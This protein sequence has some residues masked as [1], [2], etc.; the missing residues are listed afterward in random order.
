[1]VTSHLLSS[2]AAVS[3]NELPYL[4]LASADF[5]AGELFSCFVTD[6][7][8]GLG[9]P[10]RNDCS[11]FCVG[12]LLDAFVALDLFPWLEQCWLAKAAL[13]PAKFREIFG[14]RGCGSALG[15]VLLSLNRAGWQISDPDVSKNKRERSSRTEELGIRFDVNVKCDDQILLGL[16]R[17][18]L[19]RLILLTPASYMLISELFRAAKSS[20]SSWRKI[21]RLS[22]VTFTST[23]S[24]KTEEKKKKA[25]NSEP[26]ACF[27]IWRLAAC[28][29]EATDMFKATN[30]YWCLLYIW[31]TSFTSLITCKLQKGRKP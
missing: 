5:P 2:S 29:P 13:K 21:C 16:G 1:M 15:S 28:L 8:P 17:E 25:Q 22:G 26:S 20:F 30:G 11:V 3:L 4:N 31:Y 10:L 18:E 27:T 14:L 24:E 6:V 19:L 12:P 9:V 7:T 23:H